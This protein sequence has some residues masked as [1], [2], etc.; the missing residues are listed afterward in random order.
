MKV[1]SKS[2]LLFV[3]IAFTLV[4]I[5]GNSDA[6]EGAKIDIRVGLY[7]NDTLAGVNN[8][9]FAVELSSNNGMYIVHLKDNNQVILAECAPGEVVTTRKDAW[10]VKDG[11]KYVEYTP[12]RVPSK[13][14]KKG[15]FHISVGSIYGNR[16]SADNFIELLK[17]YGI[18]AYPV[19]DGRWTV[20]TGFYPDEESAWEA[21]QSVKQHAGDYACNI[22]QNRRPG[23]AIVN[24]KGKTLLMYLQQSS[25]VLTFVPREKAGSVPLVSV[26]GKSYRGRIEVYRQD[27]SDMTV[28]NEL[29]L[30][31][32]L[33]GV[34]PCEM[35]AGSHPEALKA[36]AVA[37]RT[38]A[39]RNAGKY[40]SLGFNL[41]DSPTCQVYKGYSAEHPSTNSAVDATAGELVTYNGSP[42]ATY[43]FSSSG[44]MT[45]NV[46]N[47]WGS[48]VP[49]LVSVEDSY[50][51]TDTSHYNW[52]AVYTA[53]EIR[54]ELASRSRDVGMV[55]SVNISRLSEA[56][57]VVELKI[58]GTKG[59]TVFTKSACRSALSSLY[60]QMYTISTDADTYIMDA[61]GGRTLTTLY[62]KTVA[63][64]SGLSQVKS[65]T[66]YVMGA[67]GKV[68]GIPTAP[69]VY[70]F[71]GKGWGHGVGMSQAGARG[72]AETGF[73]YK[74][75][76]TH[77]FPGTKVE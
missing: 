72:M 54:R 55:T 17:G 35:S 75:I 60:S 65:D 43:Y 36:Q 9:V 24:S 8:E 20:W 46:A 56:G 74:E 7:Y 50:E 1:F 48:E 69:T 77:Y 3:I 45:E 66:V 70:T 12:E 47:V 63:G 62:G 34:I 31:Q 49:Y 14:D 10:F 30:E 25:G 28:V 40:K 57:R 59:E 38:Y 37:S 27:G 19:F 58:T 16:Q 67:D 71:Q 61:D 76:L 4:L 64:P 51:K 68:R 32:Y 42:A 21:F 23:I 22:I 26:N 44:G 15:P 5:P 53:D 33:Y 39:V 41:S 6:H 13:G 52:E 11:D 18:N 73:N 2:R 29:G